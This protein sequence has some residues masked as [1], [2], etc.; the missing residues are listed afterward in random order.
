MAGNNS[1]GGSPAVEQL[2]RA[3]IDEVLFRLY[4]E[5]LPRLRRC[6]AL[7]SEDEIWQ[8]P[9]EAS[10]SVGNLLLH[11]CGNVG[12]WI[13][14]GLGDA[15]DRRRREQ[16]FS[17]RGPLPRAELERRL[18]DTMDRARAVIERLDPARL[19]ERRRV[20]GGDC[21]ALSILVHVVEHF[22]YHTGQVSYVV[23]ASRDCDLGYYRGRDLNKT[24]D[25]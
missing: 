25:D 13:V 23:K 4:Q 2:G 18:T 5:S 17:Q 1:S 10:N 8:R 6:L 22:S 7:L 15:E 9:G 20:Q 12:Q 3:L 21:S 14:A 24:G 16:E 19:L 11:L